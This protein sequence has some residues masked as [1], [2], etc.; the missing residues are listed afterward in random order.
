MLSVQK[1][2]I[3]PNSLLE[4]YSVD[5]GYT[6][7]Y[8]TEFDGEV[9]FSEFVSAFYTTGLFRLERYILAWTISRPSTDEAASELANGSTTTFAAWHVEQRRENEILMCDLIG[10]TRSWLM[11]VPMNGSRTRLYFGS[12]V[13]SVRNPATGKSSLGFIYQSLLGFHRLYSAL[14]LWSVKQR[15]DRRSSARKYQS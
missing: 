14:L 11:T 2:P 6:D 15:I 5:G 3:P 12:A 1:C 9:G 8:S 10:R 4:K 13:V 7:C